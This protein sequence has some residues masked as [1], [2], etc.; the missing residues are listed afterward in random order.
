VFSNV[1][2]VKSSRLRSRVAVCAAVAGCGLAAVSSASAS[3]LAVDAGGTI[4]FTAA[5]G[6]ANDVNATDV[7]VGSP[8]T[9]AVTDT[10]SRINVGSGCFAVTSHEARCPYQLGQD[11]VVDLGDRADRAQAFTIGLLDRVRV[12]GGTGNDRIEDSPQF[13][14]EVSGGTGDDKILVH[15]NFGGSVD[16]HG[17]WGDDSITAMFASGVVNGDVGDDEITLTSF[18]NPA[19]G[20]TSA[21]YGG[22]GDDRIT[23]DGSTSMSLIDGGLG[24]DTLTTTDFAEMSVINGG[25]GRDHITARPGSA[26]EING[27]AGA[28]TIN[29]GGGADTIDCGFGFDSYV[30]YEGDMAT[31]CELPFTPSPGVNGAL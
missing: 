26:E 6:E 23:A 30:V 17:D 13:G 24:D 4:R 20:G 12:T 16:V 22:F 1:S 21:A 29:G 15:P 11:L 28:D 3:T 25:F 5:R 2:A 8:S 10:G 31:R 19:G 14:A 18:F 9:M 7:D 27:G